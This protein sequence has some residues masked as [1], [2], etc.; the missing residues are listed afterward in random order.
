MDHPAFVCVVRHG[1]NL[2]VAAPVNDGT[3]DLE[4]AGRHLLI[5][6]ARVIELANEEFAAPV[7]GLGRLAR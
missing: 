2:H 6:D 1:E 7:L 5:H 4:D 3:V